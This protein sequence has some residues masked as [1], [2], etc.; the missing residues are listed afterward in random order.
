[1]GSTTL[2]IDIVTIEI[3]ELYISQEVPQIFEV[4]RGEDPPFVVTISN[5]ET[6]SVTDIIMVYRQK[7]D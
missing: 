3:V 2:K 1:M 6:V 4:F 5:Y 7:Q